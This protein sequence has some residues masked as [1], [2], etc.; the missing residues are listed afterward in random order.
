MLPN[1]LELN[2]ILILLSLI[3]LNLIVL[4]FRNIISKLLN[5]LDFPN[6]RKIHTT[7]TPLIGG[8]CLF[9]TILISTTIIFFE[10][11]ISLNKYLVLILLC[12]IFFIIGLWDD[13]TTISPKIRTF[14]LIASLIFIIPFENDFIVKNLIFK[15]VDTNINLGSFSLLF[16][17]FC[18]FSLYNALNFIDGYN[19]SA[20]SIIIFWTIILLIY[21]PNF[22]YFSLAINLII[23][24]FYNLN[25]KIFLGNSGTSIGSI[26]FALFFINDYNKYGLIYADEILLIMLF[27]GID[28]IR[29]TFERILN[30]KKIY[31]ADNTH[32]HHY[33]I[34]KKNKYIWQLMFA[35]TVCPILI[36][37]MTFN[38]H[39][40]IILEIVTYFGFLFMLRKNQDG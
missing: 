16:T 3:I 14:V 25:G 8:I 17:F 10:E 35:F 5:I 1:F 28:M 29:V 22:L 30:G 33:L 40:T 27:P 32:F 23:I 6:E 21:N 11:T 31:K 39:L 15:S 36:F 19:G 18:I 9:I 20:T 38:I 13:S 26:F 24:F 4:Y 7:P 37:N 12:L 2:L 34:K